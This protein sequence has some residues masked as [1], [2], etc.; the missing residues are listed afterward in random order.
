MKIN[1]YIFS[2]VLFLS[3]RYS[4][5]VVQQDVFHFYKW[6]RDNFNQYQPFVGVKYLCKQL[7]SLV[8][9]LLSVISLIL[10]YSWVHLLVLV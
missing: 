7:L 8:A 1:P 9:S 10:A 5:I 6:S 3:L 4:F 2:F